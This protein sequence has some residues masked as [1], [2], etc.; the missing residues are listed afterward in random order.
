MYIILIDVIMMR[1]DDLMR[2]GQATATPVAG[3]DL[4]VRHNPWL[5]HP[6]HFP[7]LELRGVRG[8]G[9]ALILSV[10]LTRVTRVGPSMKDIYVY[11]RSSD[12]GKGSSRAGADHPSLATKRRPA[13]T[14]TFMKVFAGVSFA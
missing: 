8:T 12:D 14:K 13:D 7:R 10:K 1:V 11:N 2:V 3:R 9:A 5:V 4:L 6:R